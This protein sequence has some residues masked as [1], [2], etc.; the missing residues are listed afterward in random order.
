MLRDQFLW[1]QCQYNFELFPGSKV[2]FTLYRLLQIRQTC[3]FNYFCLWFQKVSCT[4]LSYWANIEKNEEIYNLIGKIPLHLFYKFQIP[5]RRASNYSCKDI[6][7]TNPV[8]LMIFFF[9]F[10]RFL[11]HIW[12]QKVEKIKEHKYFKPERFTLIRQFIYCSTV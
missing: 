5:I 6:V 8:F 10:K 7:F 4:Y 2:Y 1:I 9:S 3:F 12:L 11:A